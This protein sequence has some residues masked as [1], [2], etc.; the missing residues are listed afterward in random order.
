MN[1]S[2]GARPSTP[3]LAVRAGAVRAQLRCG[4]QMASVIVDVTQTVGELV[5]S[6]VVDQVCKLVVVDDG[7]PEVYGDRA[8][9]LL[10]GEPIEEGR[11]VAVAPG[12]MSLAMEVDDLPAELGVVAL[13]GRSEPFGTRPVRVGGAD[14][15]LSATDGVGLMVLF[16]GG[17]MLAFAASRRSG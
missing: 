3:L 6:D 2:V 5:M 13:T 15:G 12:E 4:Q 11:P 7:V 9:L 10:N 17:M 16:A 8:R 14:G 1:V